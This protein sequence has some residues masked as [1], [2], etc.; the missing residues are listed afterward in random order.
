MSPTLK[1]RTM[2]A[3]VAAVTASPSSNGDDVPGFEACF[4]GWGV[5]QNLGDEGTVFAVAKHDAQEGLFAIL[6]GHAESG[7]QQESANDNNEGDQLLFHNF[8][9]PVDLI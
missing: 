7:Q 6:C 5:P 3:R 8:Y 2:S 4:C 1:L 9:A